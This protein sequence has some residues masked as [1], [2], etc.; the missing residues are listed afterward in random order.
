[1]LLVMS[2]NISSSHAFLTIPHAGGG[3]VTSRREMQLY[4][5]NFGN[6]KEPEQP[7]KPP[8]VEEKDAYEPDFAERI[9]T[10][11]FGKPEEEPFGLKRFVRDMDI[12]G[13][14]GMH[15]LATT[16]GNTSHEIFFLFLV[17]LF[18]FDEKGVQSLP[19][20]ISRHYYGMGRTVAGR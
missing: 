8:D 13:I 16:K 2:M 20:T 6:K 7:K 1:M 19:R 12:D 3:S 10:T 15:F 17:H 5:F 18:S 14:I 11:F 9:F 4:F